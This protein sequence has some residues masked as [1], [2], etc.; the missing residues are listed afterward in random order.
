MVAWW[1]RPRW[2]AATTTHRKIAVATT[3]GAAGSDGA[4]GRCTYC[5]RAPV[6]VV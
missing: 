1:F 6:A 3:V 2:T 4:R 5:C